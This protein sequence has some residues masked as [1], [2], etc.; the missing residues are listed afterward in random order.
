MSIIKADVQKLTEINQEI[1]R[2]R[3]EL[4]QL[5]AMKK[6][7]E[8]KVIQYLEAN[9]QPGIKCDGNTIIVQD[10]TI[11]KPVKKSEKE[12]RV[13]SYLSKYGVPTD[14]ES[15]DEL[16]DMLRGPPNKSSSLKFI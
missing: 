9:D 7:Y 14:Q 3:K 16:F 11:R 10:K 15:I 2:R 12:E 5:N 8:N 4:A 6:E 13:K 1:K